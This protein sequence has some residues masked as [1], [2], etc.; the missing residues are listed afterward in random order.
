MQP[1]IDDTLARQLLQRCAQRDETA[2]VELHRLLARRIHA[3]AWQ[4]LRDDEE[5]Q[6]V[7]I[8]TLHEVWKSAARFRGDSLVT[9]WVLGIARYKALE[10]RR[11]QAPDADDIDDHADTLAGD[12]EDG[13]ATLSRW[14]EAEQ[15]RRCLQQLTAAHREC[16]QLVYYEGLGLADVA[17][18]QQVPEGTVKTRLFHARRQMRSCV[19]GATGAAPAGGAHHG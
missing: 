19:E 11:Q 15:V 6:T 14:Q 12:V 3:F 5:S 18:V 10:Q 9:T 17:Q 7:V 8:D 2:L 1:P 13:E 4:R 16:M